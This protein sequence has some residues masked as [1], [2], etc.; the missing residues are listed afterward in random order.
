M[1]RLTNKIAG[2]PEARAA[3][4]AAKNELHRLA[5]TERSA[6]IDA[7]TDEYLAANRKVIDAE[8][9]LPK[10]RRYPIGPTD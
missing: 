1:G 4:R 3:H 9:A 7:E 8:Q 2:T 5:E 10:W 6:G